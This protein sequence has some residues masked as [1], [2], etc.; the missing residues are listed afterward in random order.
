MQNFINSSAFKNFKDAYSENDLHLF[1]AETE[2]FFKLHDLISRV[3]R[4]PLC[5]DDTLTKILY[6]IKAT[7]IESLKDA[8][9]TAYRSKT[10][11]NLA[12]INYLERHHAINE[13][14]GQ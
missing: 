10:L 11:K 14:P 2:Y 4:C 3:E 13:C 9:L 6:A 1:E 5:E 12:I 8:L 7:A